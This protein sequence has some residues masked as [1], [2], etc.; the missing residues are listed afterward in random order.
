MGDPDTIGRRT[1]VYFALVLISVLLAVSALYLGR[2][3]APRLGTWNAASLAV[4]A[5]AVAAVVVCLLMPVIDEVPPEFPAALLWRFR[6]ASLG[7]Q[8][9]L[10]S[11][12]GLAFGV[13]AERA[14]VPRRATLR[15]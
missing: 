3:L 7:T 8:A 11:G 2:R 12:I 15:A 14:L 5:F 10:W 6:L 1:V 13:L 9:L 4:A